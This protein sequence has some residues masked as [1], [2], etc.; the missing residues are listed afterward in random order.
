MMR[1]KHGL[2]DVFE[3]ALAFWTDFIRGH[4]IAPDEA[5]LPAAAG[6]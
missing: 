2:N 1:D 5:E 6:E 4:G 3:L